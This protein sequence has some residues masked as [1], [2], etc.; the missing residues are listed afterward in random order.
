MQVVADELDTVRD[1]REPEADDGAVHAAERDAVD[2]VG[3]DAVARRV[4]DL[5]ILDDVA[6]AGI[7]DAVAEAE[8]EVVEAR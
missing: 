6:V 4:D 1:G 2:V 5:E 3:P 7:E 8:L